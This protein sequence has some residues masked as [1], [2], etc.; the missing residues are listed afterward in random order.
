MRFWSGDLSVG[1]RGAEGCYCWSI[2]ISDSCRVLFK[3]PNVIDV[4]CVLNRRPHPRSFRQ[5]I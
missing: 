1:V 2:E 3:I 5:C 4:V